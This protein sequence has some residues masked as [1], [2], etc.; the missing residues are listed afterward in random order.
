MRM[1][2]VFLPWAVAATV[3]ACVV[4]TLLMGFA[5]TWRVLGQKSSPYLRNE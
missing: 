3:A 1:P 4:L 5:G 2:W